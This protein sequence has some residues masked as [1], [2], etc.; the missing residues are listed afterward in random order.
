M[1]GIGVEVAITWWPATARRGGGLSVVGGDREGLTA[2]TRRGR[3]V[4]CNRINEYIR[5]PP[6]H[7]L[8]Q[9]F[10]A[11]SEDIRLQMLALL[12]RHRELC[13]CEFERFLD[14]TQSKASRHL[15]YLLHAGLVQD[16]RDGLW[17]YYRIA[18]PPSDDRRRL[19]K[20][21][22]HLL[23]DAPL[24]DIAQQLHEMRAERCQPSAAAERPA[25]TATAESKS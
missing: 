5:G 19:L 17:V 11:L 7:D 14:L 10:K 24:P 4:S 22:R 9:L 25:A 23:R 20:A 13:V 8:A 15:R 16:R 3:V 2:L 6:M 21:L 1:S 18:E 12:F